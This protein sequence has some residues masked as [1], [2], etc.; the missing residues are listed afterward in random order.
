MLHVG[1]LPVASSVT[2]WWWFRYFTRWFWFCGF[3]CLV[4]VCG[5]FSLFSSFS[6]ISSCAWSAFY[7]LCVFGASSHSCSLLSWWG[8]DSPFGVLP[9]GNLLR[10]VIYRYSSVRFILHPL[11]V[12]PAKGGHG[13]NGCLS[14]YSSVFHL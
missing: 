4:I 13:N 3:V 7:R 9:D 10:V 8:G 11:F 12:L 2:F 6:L 5:S 1:N 14:V